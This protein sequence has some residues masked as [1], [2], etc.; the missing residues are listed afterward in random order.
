MV[1]GEK[2]SK[3]KRERGESEREAF[4]SSSG[5]DERPRRPLPDE[6]RR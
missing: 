4:N 1:G 6:G 5:S 3:R 2:K